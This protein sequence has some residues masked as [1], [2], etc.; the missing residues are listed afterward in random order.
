MESTMVTHIVEQS[1]V[2]AEGAGLQHL[3]A[4]GVL[5]GAEIAGVHDIHCQVLDPQARTPEQ[6]RWLCMLLGASQQ[7]AL[8]GEDALAVGGLL[9]KVG[10]VHRPPGPP[11][12]VTHPT[13]HVGPRCSQAECRLQPFPVPPDLEQGSPGERDVARNTELLLLRQ[14]RRTVV[15]RTRGE[16]ASQACLSVRRSA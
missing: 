14:E 13:K 3:R 7:V 12:G 8:V 6:N 2:R 5:K 9:A 15:P 10:I 16:P 11:G 4:D 1:A